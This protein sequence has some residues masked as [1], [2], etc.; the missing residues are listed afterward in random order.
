MRLTKTQQELIAK[1]RRDGGH[2][3]VESGG[4]RGAKGGAISYG[5]REMSAALGLIKLGLAVETHRDSSQIW[6]GNGNTVHSCYVAIKLVS[7]PP[8]DDQ[9][10]TALG[11]C[12]R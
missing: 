5:D 7:P 8:T 10:L 12:G 3:Q 9:F 1:A 11:P 6:M 2:V 4:G